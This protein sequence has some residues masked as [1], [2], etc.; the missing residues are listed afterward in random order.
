MDTI[1]LLGEYINEETL[2][3]VYHLI[4]FIFSLLVVLFVRTMLIKKTNKHLKS[5]EGLLNMLL[6]SI[7]LVS[8]IAVLT[9]LMAFFGEISFLFDTLF[10]IG[11]AGISLFVLILALL[12][13]FLAVKFSSL[14]KKYVLSYAYDKYQ[15]ETSMRFTLNSLFQYIVMFIAIVVSLTTLGIDLSSISIFAGVV[16]VGIGFGLQNIASNFI[17]GIILL[18]ERPIKVGDRVIIDDIFGDVL[19][20][21]MRATVVKTLDNE[22]MIIPNS[23]FLEEKVINR[24]FGDTRLRL[25]IPFGVS[26]NS[27]VFAVK[28]IALDVAWKLHKEFP[29]ILSEPEPL[30]LFMDYGDSSLDFVLL[31]WAQTPKNEMKIKSQVRFE[32]FKAFADNNI[33]IPFPQRD[34]HIRS[35]DGSAAEIVTRNL[36]K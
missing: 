31:L 33:E 10:E 15:I 30:V 11:G 35:V 8:I 16:G 7:N 14:F 29:E 23:F 36:E 22:H 1:P 4:K 28:E 24:S 9:A 6:F 12:I 5:K 19:E 32:L 18:F 26:Y 34:L 21:K 20:I 2:G 25:R 17:S 3:M 27:D 13:I